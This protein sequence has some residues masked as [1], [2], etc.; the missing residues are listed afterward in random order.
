[1]NS[2]LLHPQKTSAVS[3]DGC[4][5]SSCVE[6]EETASE[7]TGKDAKDTTKGTLIG[8]IVTCYAKIGL[9]SQNYFFS[10]I[11]MTE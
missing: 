3:E 1:M 11:G 7:K 2:K 9:T 8:I 5:S 4:S 10:N 6:K